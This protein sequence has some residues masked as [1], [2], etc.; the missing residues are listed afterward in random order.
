MIKK[1]LSGLT[2]AFLPVIASAQTLPPPPVT[3]P[4]GL[5]NNVLCPILG[6]AFTILILLAVVFVL[7]AAFRYLTA[8][9]DP[10]KVK[11]ANYT[12]LYAAIAVAVAIL[13]KAV[14]LIM[15]SLVSST[16]SVSC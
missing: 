8:A 10:E 15:G 9:G 4:G 14:P 3:T 16:I 12:L 11:H 5:I 13:A 6:W 7:V 2:T 1:V